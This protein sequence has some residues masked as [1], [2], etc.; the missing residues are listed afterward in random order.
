M[1]VEF[2]PNKEN[3]FCFGA[4]NNHVFE[5]IKKDGA[6][7]ILG[8]LP[9]TNDPIEASEE[10][11]LQLAEYIKNNKLTE[12]KEWPADADMYIEFFET[13]GGFTTY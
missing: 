3:S 9:L 7:Q 8:D 13:C 6:K 11:A 12:L 10:Q 5:L 1:T 4:P 2:V